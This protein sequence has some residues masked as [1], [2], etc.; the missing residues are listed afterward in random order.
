MEHKRIGWAELNTRIRMDDLIT[1][2]EREQSFNQF[3]YNSTS[4]EQTSLNVN[5]CIV[6]PNFSTLKLDPGR[7]PLREP[8]LRLVS[9]I[10]EGHI[11]IRRELGRYIVALLLYKIGQR[12][13]NSGLNGTGLHVLGRITQ[14]KPSK[15]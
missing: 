9:R 14:R 13:I 11:P 6:R 5:S 8:I 10:E 1:H 2:L 15:K 3:D 7:I 12:L 4:T